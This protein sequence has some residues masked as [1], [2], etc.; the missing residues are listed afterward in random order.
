MQENSIQLW[1]LTEILQLEVVLVLHVVKW[2]STVI[3]NA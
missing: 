1:V 2:T 3:P